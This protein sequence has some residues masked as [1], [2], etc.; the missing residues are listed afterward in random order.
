MK[1][2]ESLYIFLR[3]TQDIKYLMEIMI[4]LGYRERKQNEWN[5]K[6]QAHYFALYNTILMNTC[7]Y[8]DEYNKNFLA[9]AEPEF[10]ERILQIKK[11]A[12]PAFKKLN[13]WKDLKEYR[14]QMIAHNFRIDGNE[15]SFNMLGQ[16]NAPRTYRDLAL[17]RKHLAMVNAVIQAEFESDMPNINAFIKSFEVKEQEISYDNIETDLKTMVAE[18]NQLCLD[19]GKTY[20]LPIEYFIIL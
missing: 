6:D 17:L 11:I 4:D 1:L 13:E 7:S 3:Y 10:H 19:N 8:L 18:I 12:K 5:L 15:F 16:Y 20:Q 14:N 2:Y 9:K